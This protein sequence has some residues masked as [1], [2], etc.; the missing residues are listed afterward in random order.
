MAVTL[1]EAAE[2]RV[3]ELKKL[4]PDPK[5]VVMPALYIAQEE[6]GFLSDEALLWVSERS[7]VPVVHVRELATSY[8]MYYTSAVGRYHFQVC[9]TLS[10]ALGGAVGLL[11][12][13]AKRFGVPPGCAT[14]DGMWSYAQVEC[15]GACGAGPVVQVNDTYFTEMSVEKLDKLIARI[16]A[17]KPDLS[18]SVVKDSLGKGF[19]A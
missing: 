7:G 5:S 8:T 6:L 9:G 4:Y 1:S 12:H 18:F 11:Q 17:E 2:K 16:E 10:C 3:A 15:L 14:E 19:G 13:L